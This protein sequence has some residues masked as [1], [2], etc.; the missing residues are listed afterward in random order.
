A[1]HPTVVTVEDGYKA[2]G[3]GS[4]LASGIRECCEERLV[5]R[6]EILGVPTQYIDHAKVDVI[7]G[8]LG[9]DADGIRSS[10]LRTVRAP[11][12]L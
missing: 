8:R 4:L 9:L 12:P 10:V 11:S 7:M 3:A 2:G 6:I 1:G 5:P